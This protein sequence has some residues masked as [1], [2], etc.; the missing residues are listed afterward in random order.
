MCKSRVFG[1]ARI[2]TKKQKI[3][4]QIDN[5]KK[6]YPDAAI[7][8]EAFTGTKIDRPAFNKLINNI[9][10]GDTIV[11]DEV[12]RMSRNAEEGIA[13]YTELFEKGV[14]LVFIKEPHINTSV[15]REKMKIHI[16]KN[17]ESTGSKPTDKFINALMDA[18]QDYAIDLAKEQVEL[19][20][21]TAQAEVDFLHQRTSEGVRKAQA[22]GKQVGRRDGLK[23]ETKKAKGAKAIILK[24]SKDFNGSNTD[25]EVIRICGIS[26]N[27]YYKYKRE[28][29]E[30][31][32]V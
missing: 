23:V 1:Y 18:L 19:A 29:R 25:D 10:E 30:D 7:I 9:K 20:F 22:E 3:E 12:S 15:Y 32:T 5:I 4:R 14:N 2:S 31:A 17:I 16:E 24:N 13:L 11:F 21:K 6:L 28:L 27:S 26:R 8:Q